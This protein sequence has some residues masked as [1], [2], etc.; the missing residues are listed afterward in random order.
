MLALVLVVI[1][2]Y[3]VDASSAVSD[4]YALPAVSSAPAS[5][6]FPSSSSLSPFRRLAYLPSMIS[7][8]S[9]L[10]RSFSLVH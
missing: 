3:G 8:L 10:L 5:S 2:F 4:A 1:I 6:S 9:P 7:S